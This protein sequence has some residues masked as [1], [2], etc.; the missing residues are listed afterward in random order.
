MREIR[1]NEQLCPSN[2]WCVGLKACPEKAIYQV[3]KDKPPK[4]DCY[5]CIKCNIC[6]DLCPYGAIQRIKVF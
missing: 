6:I 4:V 1:V 5:R 3:S 2:H